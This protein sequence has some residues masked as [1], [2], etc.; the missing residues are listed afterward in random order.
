[1]ENTMKYCQQCGA[2]VHEKAVICVSCGCK[3][4][5]AVWDKPGC[6]LCGLAFMFPL[7]GFILYFVWRGKRPERAGAIA[8]WGW[9]GFG[10]SFIWY[11]VATLAGY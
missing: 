10:L 7:I 2:E 3:I 4:T 6:F 5:D 8:M 9:I 11:I 1:M